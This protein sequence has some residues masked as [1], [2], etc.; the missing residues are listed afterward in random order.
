MYSPAPPWVAAVPESGANTATSDGPIRFLY[1]DNQIRVAADGTEALYTAYRIKILTPE[2]LSAGNITAAWQPDN[3]SLTVHA[4]KLI[5]NGQAT[6]ILAATRF[7]VL[8]RET[9]LEQ[10]MLDGVRTATLQVP[11]LQVGDEIEFA[12]TVTR[13]EPIFAGKVAGLMSFPMLGAPG[14]FRDRLIWPADQSLDLR[15]S[16]DLGALVPTTERGERVVERVL[17]HPDGAVPT[18]GAPTRYNVRRLIEYSDFGN[19]ADLGSV[20][21]APFDKAAVLAPD[22]PVRAE[23]AAIAARTSDPAARALAALE[24]VE[25]RIRYVFIGLDGGN[26]MPAAADVTWQRRFGDCKAKSVLLVAILRALGIDAEPALVNSNGGDGLDERLPNP[27]LFDHVVVRAMIDGGP[28]WLDGTRLGDHNLKTLPLPWRWALPLDAD[29][30]GL[31]PIAPRDVAAP[32]VTG[33]VDIDASAGFDKDAAVTMQ[34]IL[35]GD[36]AFTL[37]TKLSA[38]SAEDRDRQLKAYWRQQVDWLTPDTVSW[39]YDDKQ[40]ALS[41]GVSGRGNPGWKGDAKS[42]HSLTIVGA[43]FF[44]PDMMRRPAEQDQRASW[45]VPFPRFHCWATTIHLPPAEA[46]LRW[47]LYAD[48]MDRRLGGIRYWRA[49]GMAGNVVRTLMSTHSYEPEATVNEAMIVNLAIP[50]FNNN[51]SS[52]AEEKKAD[53]VPS[54]TKLPFGDGVDWLADPAPCFAPS[55]AG[56]AS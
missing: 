18:E 4:L 48:P 40:M 15:A 7:T 45:S 22:S 1:L 3:G 28:V 29:S 27:E 39:H 11:G 55:P 24:L 41:L 14:T 54:S 53:V 23:V 34:T 50:N 44:A 19:W 17:N 32:Q 6:D 49:S 37:D 25:S 36:D 46:P 38:L 21:A 31:E 52:I 51:M 16:K 2:G 43:G 9:Q 35:R 12:A 30:V 5:R 42:G 13:H 10:S 56:A 33:V 47:S 20:M 26:Y 8:Q